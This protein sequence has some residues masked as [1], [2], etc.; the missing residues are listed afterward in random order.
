MKLKPTKVNYIEV[1]M[2]RNCEL[3]DFC[4]FLW[5]FEFCTRHNCFRK[6]ITVETT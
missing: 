5:N 1:L 4:L 6:K 2:P 3:W